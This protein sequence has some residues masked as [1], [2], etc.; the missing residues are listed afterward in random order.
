MLAADQGTTNEVP[1]LQIP[2]FSDVHISGE[3]QEN[4][5][6]DVLNDYKKLAPGYKAMAVVGDI[7]NHGMESQYDNFNKI[8][9]KYANPDAEK[10]IAMGNHEFFEGRF[11]PRPDL[12]DKVLLDRFVSKTGMPGVYY[13][14]WVE[15]YHFI[16]L[17]SEESMLTDPNNQHNAIISDKQYKW[18]EETLPKEA[19]PKK[20][21]FVFLHQPIDDTVY[22]SED[23]GGGL[24]DGRLANILKQYPQVIL[25]TGHL[26]YLLEHPR[27]VYQDGF[28]M[29][30]TGA[31]AY[32]L[33]EDG[34]GPWGSAQGLLVNVFDDRV[35]IK[36]REFSTDTWVN[37]YTIKMPF[38]QTIGDSEKP[39]FKND[40]TVKI[41]EIK[42]NKVTI[43]WESALDNTLVDKYEIKYKG[44]TIHKEYVRFWEN[45]NPKRIYTT[46]TNLE[47]ETQYD[48]E[49][50]ALD[51]W[52]NSSEKPLTFKVTTSELK[53]W[54]ESEG[55]R[56]YYDPVTKKKATGWLNDGG[57][58][59]YL[60]SDG[61]MQ[62][63]WISSGGNWYYLAKS[64]IMQVGWI[65][66]NGTWYYLSSGGAMQ[67]G[68]L[69]S[70]GIWYYL[71]GNGAMQTGWISQG[72]KWYY[73]ASSG[74]MKTGWVKDSE[75]WYYLNSS[76]AMHTGWLNSGGAWYYLAGNGAMQ[77]GRQYVVNKWYNF[78]SSGVMLAG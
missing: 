5:L 60:G 38:E 14:K 70:G 37:S 20:P 63:G 7:T 15:G 61:I 68:W 54:V 65:N 47:P 49:I 34:S 72:T 36:A 33:Y 6:I 32:T 28:T 59:Y 66:D 45:K 22:G 29:V 73:L 76:G 77:T 27:T 55:T 69:N 24:R 18:L 17:G 10:V 44:K 26:H 4:K 50:Y 67:T 71:A 64:G 74:A 31:T 16:T 9:D 13:D 3:L 58:W 30:N 52:R 25:F 56:S 11:W 1:K 53:G 23:W 39:Y 62:T 35:E 8:M 46:I 48:L 40:S 57:R 51:A 19:D 42:P 78:D 43:S 75:K 12:T 21:I 2:V 41:E